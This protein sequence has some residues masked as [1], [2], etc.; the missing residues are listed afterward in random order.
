MNHSSFFFSHHNYIQMPKDRLL[1][2]VYKFDELLSDLHLV[3]NKIAL[4]TFMTKTY[5]YMEAELQLITTTLLVL[6]KS[7]I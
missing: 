1:W 6:V 5:I 7:E 4:I 3:K 2:Y